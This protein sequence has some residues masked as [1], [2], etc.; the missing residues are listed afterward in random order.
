[1][2]ESAVTG[3]ESENQIREIVKRHLIEITGLAREIGGPDAV[4]EKV[5][6]L[7]PDT[8]R[9]APEPKWTDEQIAKAREVE[10]KLG[11]GAEHNVTSG[12]V[13]GVRMPEG[14]LAWKIAAEV[15][16]LADEDP[17]AAIVMTGSPY[18]ILG[19]DAELGKQE[20]KFMAERYGAEFTL[21]NTEYD[22]AEWFARRRV[23]EPDERIVNFGYDLSQ[24][25][26]SKS[27]PT[28]Q[29]VQLGETAAG[30]PVYLLRV[31]QEDYKNEEGEDKY[32][33]KPDP[34]R[35]MELVAEA[36]EIDSP[37]YHEPV[38]FMTSNAYASRQ[39]EAIRAGVKSGR[40]FGVAMYGRATLAAVKGT[41][42]LPDVE[43]NQVPGDLRISYDNLRQLAEML[44]IP[45][46]EYEY[47][48]RGEHGM[49]QFEPDGP[50]FHEEV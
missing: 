49:I 25:N 35:R 40:Q 41:E 34:A 17:D 14:G 30:K 16:A 15:E 50:D 38:G 6:D 45:S 2:S 48:K 28:G 3:P 5:F 21:E 37:G 9:L 24:G 43:L 26:P 12:L 18:R 19:D 13:G 32:R 36:L 47:P 44:K 23:Q 8:R 29:L 27:E 22:L 11:Y 33:F 1:M 39:F 20:I 10:H 7:P 46:A 31:D 42:I 4:V